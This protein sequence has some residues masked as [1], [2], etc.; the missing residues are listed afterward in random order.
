L[1]MEKLA[2]FVEGQTE[3]IFTENLLLA[4]AG[5]RNYHIDAIQAYGGGPL[6]PR[7]W[8]EIHA[9]RP[10]PKTEYYILIYE[11]M[12]DSRVLSD[13][14]DQYRTL[15]D[16]GFKN[17]IGIRD[18]YPEPPGDIP[19]IRADFRTYV[20]VGRVVPVLILEIMEIEAWFIGEHTHFPKMDPRLT[21]PAVTAALGYEP[22]AHDV[23]SISWPCQDIRTAYSL[24]GLGYNKSRRHVERTA[25][26]LSYEEVYVTLRPR[27]ADLHSLLVELETFFG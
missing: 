4:L 26:V 22:S 11:C 5:P 8:E 13:I 10:D 12:N 3:R 16:Q 14:R 23:T 17:I 2:I 24:A 18:V 25:G 15:A 19:T 27:I 20:P 7:T 6:L 21:L 1:R 9:I